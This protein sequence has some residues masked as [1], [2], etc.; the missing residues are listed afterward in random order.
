M[1][2]ARWSETQGQADFLL[3]TEEEKESKLI[4]SSRGVLVTLNNLI[5]MIPIEWEIQ[6][7][8]IKLRLGLRF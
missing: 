2:K 3:V 4:T 1:G 5:D 8:M 6:I 7:Q